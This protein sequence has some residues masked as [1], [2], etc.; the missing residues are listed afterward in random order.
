MSLKGMKM[1]FGLFSLWTYVF[2]QN[3]ILT[4]L[5]FQ[6]KL[7]ILK[8]LRKIVHN[9]VIVRIDR[10]RGE[11]WIGPFSKSKRNMKTTQPL[12]SYKGQ[13]TANLLK[14]EGKTTLS[15]ARHGKKHNKQR[16]KLQVR[17]AWMQRR[18]KE[19]TGFFPWYR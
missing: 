16:Y 8:N 13:F 12:Q 7:D 2:R 11:G 14:Q 3:Q 4:P 6:R 9:T 10:P 18:G 5:G 15:K 17:N 1:N 19:T